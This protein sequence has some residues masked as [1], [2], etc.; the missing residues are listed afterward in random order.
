ML[1]CSV[2]ALRAR[3]RRGRV[4]STLSEGRRWF[5]LDHLE[6]VVRAEVAQRQR[7]VAVTSKG[8]VGL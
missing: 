3:A 4:P 6:L 2:V 8:P 1:G 7:R 5:R